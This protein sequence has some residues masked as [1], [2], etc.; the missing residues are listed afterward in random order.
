M[1]DT[2]QKNRIK[3]GNPGPLDDGQICPECAP[4][5]IC[6]FGY[7]DLDIRPMSNVNQSK[8]QYVKARSE[9]LSAC[10]QL[11]IFAVL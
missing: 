1:T 2:C 7:R 3:F 4:C 8:A 11:I 5:K 9:Y 10:P 6:G